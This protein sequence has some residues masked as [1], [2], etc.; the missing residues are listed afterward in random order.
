[1]IGNDAAVAFA[2]TQGNFELN[3]MLPVMARNLLESITAAGYEA[4][5]KIAKH[6]VAEGLT[7]RE[8]VVSL[9]Y[10]SR[11]RITEAQ[12]DQALDV[13]AMTIAPKVTDADDPHRRRR[14]RRRWGGSAG[15][16]GRGREGPQA[17]RHD[18]LQ[19]LPD[20]L[21][22]GRRRRWRRRCGR[23]GG[24]AGEALQRHGSGGDWL[25]DQD[26]VQYF[27]EHAAEEM[28]QLERWG[29]P[30][31]RKPNG[32]INVRRFGGMSEPRTW[33]AADK[34]GFHMLH[35]LFQTSLKHTV[36]LP[37]GRALRSRPGGQRRPGVRS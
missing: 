12:L 7:V 36:D 29:C 17:D 6:S 21:A 19:G 37:A 9:G 27:V 20:A 28:Y 10:V 35:T 18:H 1:V 4:A 2:G 8:S 30:W 33:F 32:E 22:H 16:A 11:G 13:Y 3:V 14:D 5:A 25:C 26:V 31:S 23:G 24:L 15:G 34:T